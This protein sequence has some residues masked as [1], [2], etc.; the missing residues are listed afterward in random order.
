[1]FTN[2]LVENGTHRE[3]FVKKGAIRPRKKKTLFGLKFWKTIENI[4]SKFFSKK[5]HFGDLEIFV[6]FFFFKGSHFG[7]Q[8]K[9]KSI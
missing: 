4:F 7:H 2:N 3:F 1:M 6:F 5:R 9:K 8:K